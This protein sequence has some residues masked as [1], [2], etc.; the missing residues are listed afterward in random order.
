MGIKVVF[1]F[2]N[3]CLIFQNMYLQSQMILMHK[4]VIFEAIDKLGIQN[5]GFLKKITCEKKRKQDVN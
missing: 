5:F 4:N 1:I 3:I 2:E